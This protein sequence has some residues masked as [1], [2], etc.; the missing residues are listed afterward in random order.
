MATATPS[1]KT[2]DV[3]FMFCKLQVADIDRAAKFYASVFG[4]V[5]MARFDAEITGRAVTEVVFMPTYD[6][7]P[8][9]ILAQFHDVTAPAANELI[10]GFATKD[11]DALI[12]RAEAAGGRVLERKAPTDHAPFHTLFLAD[13]EGHTVQVSQAAG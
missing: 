4:L 7:G 8:M 9:F 13:P 3:D 1:G 11:M 10:L 6:G 12:A 2:L 5:Q